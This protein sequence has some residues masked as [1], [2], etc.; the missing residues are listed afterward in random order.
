MTQDITIRSVPATVISL[1]AWYSVRHLLGLVF[2]RLFHFFPIC[3]S[4]LFCLFLFWRFGVFQFL[5]CIGN[6]VLD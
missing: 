1:V 5:L 2:R 6:P 3:R 4:L